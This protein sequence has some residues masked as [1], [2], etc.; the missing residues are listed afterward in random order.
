MQYD[1]IG[2]VKKISYSVDAFSNDEIYSY[3][4]LYRLIEADYIENRKY[5]YN[6]KPGVLGD[7]E[8]LTLTIGGV[9]STTDY[10][11]NQKNQLQSEAL[12]GDGGI[13]STTY[14]NNG[15]AITIITPSITYQFN[16]DSLNRMTSADVDG[17]VSEYAY[18]YTNQRIKKKTASGTTFYLTQG[19]NVIYEEFV[20]T[21]VCPFT[22]GNVDGDDADQIDLRDV[23][24]FT[25]FLY[26]QGGSTV[27]CASSV[28]GDNIINKNDLVYLIDYLYNA[29]P[30]PICP[31]GSAQLGSD[32]QQDWTS[33]DIKTYIGSLPS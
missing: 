1:L 14:D 31:A 11:Y 18:D 30:A 5:N 17:E 7:R 15:N 2:N 6:Y 16:Y 19:N 20:P 4:N 32:P 33:D 25:N 8:L 21:G 28:D 26:G 27:L 9:P 22:C 24:Y 13:T 10:N 12:S 29:G 23:E 3:D